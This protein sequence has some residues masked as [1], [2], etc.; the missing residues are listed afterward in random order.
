MSWWR[1]LVFTHR[2]TN[3]G[4]APGFGRQK[5]YSA[6]SGYV[7]QYFL[8]FF[9][10]GA[11]TFQL[12][13]ARKTPFRAEVVL[14]RPVLDSW[15]AEHGRELTASENYAIAKIALK[16]RL[17]AASAPDM[18]PRQIVIDQAE[19]SDIAIYLDL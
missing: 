5:T 1:N 2:R 9:R 3:Y 10:P 4:G 12:T 8:E 13:A 18:V 11:Y 14:Q 16:R 17:D 15:R 19:V 6:E 7:Y